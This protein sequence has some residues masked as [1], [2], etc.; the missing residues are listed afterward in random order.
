MTPP[1]PSSPPA[2]LLVLFTDFGARGP[3]MGQMRAALLQNAPGVPIITL[4]AD[5]PAYDVRAAAYLLAAYAPDMGEG[6]VFVCVVDPG[7]G[8]DRPPMVLRAGGQ[9]FVGPGNGLFEIIARRA[10]L[11]E[12]RRIVWQP[13]RLSPSFHGRDLFAPMA[14]AL[15]RGDEA[16]AVAMDDGEWRRRDWPDDLAQVIYLDHFGNAITG[17][18]AAMLR[19]GQ[20]LSAGE[21]CLSQARTFSGVPIGQAF[22]YENANGLVEFAVNQGSAARQLQLEPGAEIGIL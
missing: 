13:G 5:A 21:A 8:G 18:R 9:T 11:F 19:P 12:A 17:L 16:E 7:V 6:A 14:A 22:W 2:P 10:E 1:T 4:F 15:A 20:V 3:Y